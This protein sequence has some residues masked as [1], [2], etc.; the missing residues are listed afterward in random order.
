MESIARPGESLSEALYNSGVQTAVADPG[1]VP[2]GSIIVNEAIVDLARGRSAIVDATAFR[3]EADRSIVVDPATVDDHVAFFVVDSSAIPRCPA[4]NREI[5]ERHMHARHDTEYAVA[6]ATVDSGQV[7]T[8]ASNG[9][10]ASND[11]IGVD[12]ACGK[13]DNRVGCI[14]GECL[15]NDVGRRSDDDAYL[16][17]G[18]I[19]P[20]VL[21]GQQIDATIRS[22][23]GCHCS[24]RR[25]A[26]I[27]RDGD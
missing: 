13:E 22:N 15:L 16:S 9:N 1:A 4:R 2:V 7:H 26:G 12:R 18:W 27:K 24:I 6:A 25:P 8:L 23:G 5:F 10:V 21:D 19:A 17:Y 14:I 11:G 20:R 3:S